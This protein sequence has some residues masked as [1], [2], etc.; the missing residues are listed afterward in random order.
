MDIEEIQSLSD[1]VKYV[2]RAELT[3]KVRCAVRNKAEGRIGYYN[4]KDIYIVYSNPNEILYRGTDESM[5]I[6]VLKDK[7]REIKEV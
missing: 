4:F 5:V 6:E 3:N 7:I 1:I 2:E